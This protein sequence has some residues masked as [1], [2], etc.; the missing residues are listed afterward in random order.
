MVASQRR[1]KGTVAPTEASTRAVGPFR[2]VRPSGSKPT[3][4]WGRPESLGLARWL[5]DSGW[6]PERREAHVVPYGYDRTTRSGEPPAR[7]EKGVQRQ[8]WGA[9][10]G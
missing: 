4:C 9:M 6:S 8:A 2:R 10:P 5:T 1:E 7:Y 3:C